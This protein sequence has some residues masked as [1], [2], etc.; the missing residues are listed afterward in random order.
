ML[1]GFI[2]EEIK[3]R[4]DERRRRE[5]DRPSVQVPDPPAPSRPSRQGEED[6]PRRGVVIIEDGAG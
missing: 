4:D 5:I 1:D 3:R 2:I 6:K